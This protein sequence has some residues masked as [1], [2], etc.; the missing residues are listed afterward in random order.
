MGAQMLV[1]NN[2]LRN[3]G[4]AVPTNRSRDVDGY[5]NLRGKDL[6]GAATEISRAGTFTAPPCSY[7]AESAST[8]VASVTSGA[9]AGKL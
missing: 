2:V 6:G 7:T 9:G 5:A 8:V 4:V 3:T 1:E